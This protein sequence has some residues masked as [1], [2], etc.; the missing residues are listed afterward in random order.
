M[1]EKYID[2]LKYDRRNIG[3]KTYTVECLCERCNKPFKVDKRGKGYRRILR[4]QSLVCCDCWNSKVHSEAYYK[5][6]D[7]LMEVRAKKKER[8]QEEFLALE[9]EE[10]NHKIYSIKELNNWVNEGHRSCTCICESCGKEHVLPNRNTMVK[11][12]T[13]H[14]DEKSLLCKGCSISKKKTQDN[15][16]KVLGRMGDITF[17]E[18]QI[19]EGGDFETPKPLRKKYTFVCNRCG[20]EFESCFSFGQETEVCCPNCDPLRNGV[21]H[22]EKQLLEYIKSIYK[23]EIIENY[24][25]LIYPYEVDIYL[26]TLNLAIE[27]DGRYWHNN[28]KKSF[29]KFN[30][31]KEK[32]VR[33]VMIYD[34]E[35]E[36][37]SDKI[38]SYLKSLICGNTHKVGARNCKVQA[39]DTKEAEAFIERYHLQGSPQNITNNN[40]VCLGLYLDGELM[41]IETFRKAR[42][43]SKYDWELIRE[44]SKE[45]WNI[46]GGKSKILSEFRKNYNGSIVSYCDKRFFSG[47]SYE[48]CGFTLMGETPSDYKYYKNG[49]VYSREQF[50]KHKLK[51]KLENF[52]ELLTETENMLNNGY[53]KLYDFGNYVYVIN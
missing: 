27:Y 26:P 11:Y 33:L 17:K 6:R 12:N 14:K 35:W 18:G 19:Y 22:Q 8:N 32:G 42:Y 4:E 9:Q 48:E 25:H 24:K 50:M 28:S 46:I 7:T 30:L 3:V 44:C 23:G 38:K 52:N 36:Q 1:L 40:T 29:M 51:D 31:C 43:S 13:K 53:F 5:G 10:V 2:F 39:V 15:Q 37:N 49:R 34:Y 16:K 41:Q 45:G 21:S 20:K 47:K